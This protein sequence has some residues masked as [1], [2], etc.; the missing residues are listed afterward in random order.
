MIILCVYILLSLSPSEI[1]TVDLSLPVTIKTLNWSF[2]VGSNIT[3][4]I[5]SVSTNTSSMIITGVHI[6]SPIDCPSVNVSISEIGVKSK[7]EVAEEWNIDTCSS[8]HL[9]TCGLTS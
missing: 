4:N 8:I 3:L 5:S 6:E 1:I 9:T 7:T 2:R